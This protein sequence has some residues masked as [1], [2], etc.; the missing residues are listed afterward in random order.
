MATRE[1]ENYMLPRYETSTGPHVVF[2]YATRRTGALLVAPQEALP[3][4]ASVRAE[5]ACFSGDR[6]PFAFRSVPV[7]QR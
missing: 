2:P 1:A 5:S 7:A 4:D 3:Q 6:G